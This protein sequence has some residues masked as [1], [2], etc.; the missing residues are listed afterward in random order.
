MTN[1]TTQQYEVASLKLCVLVVGEHYFMQLCAVA[2]Q[3]HSCSLIRGSFALKFELSAVILLQSSIQL[4]CHRVRTEAITTVRLLRLFSGEAGLFGPLRFLP[5]IL[6]KPLGLSFT[7]QFFL[8]AKCLCYH[9]ANSIKALDGTEHIEAL[10][11]AAGKIFVV[12]VHVCL[13][14][15]CYLIELHFCY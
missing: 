8:Q 5:F 14:E 11:C 3:Q 4:N 9:P 13:F 1:C 7:G 10:L 2:G 15:L 6:Q 12:D